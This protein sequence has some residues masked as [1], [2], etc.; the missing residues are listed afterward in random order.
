V[1]DLQV[2]WDDLV[3][4]HKSTPGRPKPSG[5]Q[6]FNRVADELTR[7]LPQT[8]AD[9]LRE[10]DQLQGSCS[11]SPAICTGCGAG[12]LQH[13]FTSKVL[14]ETLCATC[15]QERKAGTGDLP[16]KDRERRMASR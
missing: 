5:L 15:F 6:L 12:N 7:T 16:R 11:G 9:A 4:R 13:F 2:L 3:R 1:L 14:G 10:L 8:A